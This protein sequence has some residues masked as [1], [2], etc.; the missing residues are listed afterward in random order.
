MQRKWTARPAQRIRE[1]S[2][3]FTRRGFLGLS[4]GAASALLVR[5]GSSHPQPPPTVP[6]DPFT[7][8]AQLQEA[9]RQSPDHR[10]AAADKLVAR[11]DPSALLAFVRD[12]IATC[13]PLDPMAVVTEMRWGVRG[14]LRGGM[15]TPR[16]KAELLVQLYQRAGFTAQVVTGTPMDTSTAALTAMYFRT[17]EAPFNPAIDQTTLDGFNA[18]LGNT[19]TP[20]LPLIDGSGAE[21]AAIASAV[22]SALP[23]GLA[24]QG[25]PD[26]TLALNTLNSLPLVAVQVGGKTVANR[27]NLLRRRPST[28]THRPTTGAALC[29]RRPNLQ[30]RRKLSR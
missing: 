30:L 9:L 24:P 25:Q 20:T 29:P 4:V 10:L 11:R 18:T 22:W 13:P 23:P 28:R 8:W 1:S 3:G 16:E 14:T 5:C 2:A 12:Q 6:A 21:A 15:G 26:P 19:G 7:I 17:P 27:P